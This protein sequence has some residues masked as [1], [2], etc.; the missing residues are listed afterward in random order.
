VQIQFF[1]IY[2]LSNRFKNDTFLHIFS[3]EYDDHSAIV[4]STVQNTGHLMEF[5][6]AAFTWKVS[7]LTLNKYDFTDFT[8]KITHVDKC[9]NTTL[10]TV[11]GI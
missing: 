1:H 5:F 6:L 8:K 4:D 7:A 3:Q 9:F 11:T 2:F 10:C